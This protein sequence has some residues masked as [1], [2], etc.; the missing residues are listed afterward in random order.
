MFVYGWTS[1]SYIHWIFPC[2]GL[3]MVGFGIQTV[4]AAACDYLED[5]YADSD[6]AAT[7]VG[8]LAFL[9]NIFGS[10][11]PFASMSMYTHL[12]F[13]WASTL[14]G[15]VAVLIS[16]G[17][18]LFTWKGQWFRQRSPF[19]SSGGLSAPGLTISGQQ[20]SRSTL[21]LSTA[22]SGQQSQRSRSEVNLNADGRSSRRVT[23]SGHQSPH[24]RSEANLNSTGQRVPAIPAIPAIPNNT[25][26]T[27]IGRS[28]STPGNIEALEIENTSLKMY[29]MEL[30]RQLRENGLE[31]KALLAVTSSGEQSQHSRSR[32]RSDVN[33][34]VPGG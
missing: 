10:F 5:A 27:T 12:G 8:A 28:A 31:P 18:M 19:M 17:P 7:A 33:L 4:V 9:E 2:I 34:N 1:Y 21:A 30:Q 6:Y 23:F 16:V 3:A 11:L 32:S 22:G 13:Q 14:L 15:L 20:R 25:E 29:M 26:R 24:S